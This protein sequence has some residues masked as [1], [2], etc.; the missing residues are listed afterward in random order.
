M[1]PDAAGLDAAR[2]LA[3]SKMRASIRAAIDKA[4]AGKPP[5]RLQPTSITLMSD[6]TTKEVRCLFPAD[7]PLEVRSADVAP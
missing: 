6:T 2:E 3:M 5:M 1:I 7:D 4:H